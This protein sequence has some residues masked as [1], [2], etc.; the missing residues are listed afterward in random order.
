MDSS[1]SN[2]PFILA[3]AVAEP[4]QE[5]KCEA[6]L[7]HAQPIIDAVVEVCHAVVCESDS[8]CDSIDEAYVQPLGFHIY[9]S[10]LEAIPEDSD[11]CSED[12]DDRCEA[13]AS[14]QSA[15][16]VSLDNSQMSVKKAAPPAASHHA[17]IMPEANRR[18][19]A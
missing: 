6:P 14:M 11:Y 16:A 3:P 1:S 15:K 13:A 19:R 10:F 5:A 4:L 17:A 12:E 2:N 7:V 8:D 9:G 18:T